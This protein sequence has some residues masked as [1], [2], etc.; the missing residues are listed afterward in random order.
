MRKRKTYK[1]EVTS[2]VENFTEFNKNILKIYSSKINKF[3][4]KYL[5]ERIN[6]FDILNAQ[7]LHLIERVVL[8]GESDQLYQR[9]KELINFYLSNEIP[10]ENLDL[11]F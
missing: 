2:L 1:E 7:I 5:E 3:Y 6:N 9:I 4:N 8:E 11:F 10:E